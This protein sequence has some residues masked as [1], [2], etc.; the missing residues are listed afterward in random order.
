MN[1]RRRSRALGA[2]TGLTAEA[3]QICAVDLESSRHAQRF[4]PSWPIL[5][6]SRTITLRALAEIGVSETDAE[7]CQP[8]WTSDR[9][10]AGIFAH[11]GPRELLNI[12]DR[13]KR[14]RRL[15]WYARTRPRWFG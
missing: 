13:M 3:V 15:D 2:M 4:V 12:T 6:G 14:E 5:V 1:F 8:A 9:R 7:M 11:I 10:D